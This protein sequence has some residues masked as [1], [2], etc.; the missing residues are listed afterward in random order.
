M[1]VYDCGRAMILRGNEAMSSFHFEEED[2]VEGKPDHYKEQKDLRQPGP[3]PHH[4][5]KLTTRLSVL[6]SSGVCHTPLFFFLSILIR[7]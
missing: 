6:L 3:S 5:R 4:Q 1:I 2:H 7:E